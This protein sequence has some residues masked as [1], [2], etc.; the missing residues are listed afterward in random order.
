MIVQALPDWQH[1]RLPAVKQIT[2]LG[3]STLWELCRKGQFPQPLRLK[4][5][6]MTVWRASDV[7]AWLEAKAA[8]GQNH[9]A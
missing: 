7:K 6:R 1:L 4:S 2:G 9:A 5:P 8:E 3:G